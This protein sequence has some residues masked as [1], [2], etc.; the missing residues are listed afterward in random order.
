MSQMQS[1]EGFNHW[2]AL[3]LGA[4]MVAGAAGIGALYRGARFAGRMGRGAAGMSRNLYKQG[5]AAA[6]DLGGPTTKW[7]RGYRNP[8][9]AP[10]TQMGT[11]VGPS[12]FGVHPENPLV[13]PGASARSQ[14]QY[15]RSRW[16]RP[17]SWGWRG[18]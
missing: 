2:G 18:R 17:A 12:R 4:G 15:M 16:D 6:S 14:T 13:G 10:E 1:N 9:F 5:L 7:G 8:A 11:L 3:A